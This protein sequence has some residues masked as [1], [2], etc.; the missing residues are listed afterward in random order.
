MDISRNE[1]CIPR[2]GIVGGFQSG[3]STLI[4]CLLQDRVALSGFGLACTRQV[5]R[6][7]FAEKTVLK[8]FKKN[9]G[10][11]YVSGNMLTGEVLENIIGDNDFCFCEIGLPHV[12]LKSVELWDTPGFDSDERDTAVTEDSLKKLD[13]AF[14]LIPG[15]LRDPD[16]QILRLLSDKEIPYAVLY[17]SKDEDKW[18]PGSASNRNVRDN[19]V[20]MMNNHGLGSGISVPGRSVVF[21]INTAWYWYDIVMRKKS[22][23][24]LPAPSGE[25]ML[26][27]RIENSLYYRQG[28]AV[29]DLKK[30][31]GIDTLRNF[32]IRDESVFGNLHAQLGIF[33]ELRGLRSRFCEFSEKQVAICR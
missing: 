25:K 20:A 29:A 17:N 27:R 13:F 2:I 4:N 8:A 11:P 16:I 1:N 33:R 10:S 32:L 24:M 12:L 19:C 21:S 5:T 9:I 30:A 14:V 26:C 31:S 15:A 22:D 7:F 6:Y 3:K 18:N 23:L 28:T